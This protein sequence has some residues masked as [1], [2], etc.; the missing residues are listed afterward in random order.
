[1]RGA[2][3]ENGIVV[4][5]WEVP[6]LD[7]FDGVELIDP[8]ESAGVGWLY[9]NGVFTAPPPTAEQQEEAAK[10]Q[11]DADKLT[12]VEILGVM[13][14]ATGKDQA[15]LS[16]VAIGAMRAKIKGEVFAPTAFKFE[17]GAELVITPDNFNEIEAIWTPFRQS[18]FTP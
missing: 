9:E 16:A 3:I 14:S 18:F 5:I 2:R 13:C 15:G 7:A 17:N 1:M 8:T 10:Q 6:S 11:A 12:G 4:A